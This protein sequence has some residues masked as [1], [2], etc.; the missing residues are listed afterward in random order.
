M[1]LYIALLLVIALCTAACEKRLPTIGAGD[2]DKEFSS[3][4]KLSSKG[5][6]EKSVQCLEM[7]KARYPDTRLGQEAE[8]RIGDAYYAKKDL[9]LAAESYAAYIRLHPRGNKAD[10]AHYMIGMS[11]FKESP[12]A[13]DR[14]Q[15]YLEK[16]IDNFKVVVRTFPDS[17]YAGS[18]KDYLHRARL[19]IAK[20]NFYVGKFY[21]KTGEY[22]ASIP[23]FWEVVDKYPDSGLADKALYKIITANMKLKKFDDAKEAY[24][25]MQ[26]SFPDNRLTKHAERKLLSAAK[27]MK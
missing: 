23:R 18:A 2:P 22:I 15:E 20:R 7:F 24:S 1:R 21:F 14:D 8:L 13:I 6:F 3:C 27:R 4:L 25:T 5:D 9:L 26:T 11:Y 17:A 10:Y 16:A 19:R 12:K